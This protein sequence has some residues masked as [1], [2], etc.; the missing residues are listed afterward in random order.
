MKR[1]AS[2][3]FTGG[4]IFSTS[5]NKL[6]EKWTVEQ[7]ELVSFYPKRVYI[8]LQQHI[9]APSEAVVKKGDTVKQG[10]LI[11]KAGGFVGAN[12]HASVS[13]K[14]LDVI[15]WPDSSGKKVPT[16]VIQRDTE[17][18]QELIADSQTDFKTLSK[19]ELIE[20]VS[21]AGVVG[22]GGATFPTHVKLTVDDDVEVKTIVLNGAECE[23]FL[24]A[25][26]LLMQ[27]E[28]KKVI[29]GAQIA[30]KI[31]GAKNILIAIE[32]DK[33]KAIAA[34]QA[35]AAN[36]PDVK[37]VP[38]H[39]N[40]PQGGEKQLLESL[41]DI[42]VDLDGLPVDSGAYLMNVSTSAAVAEA[43]ES[44][45]PLI[46]RYCT[47]TGD[48]KKKQTVLFPIG[49]L[50]GDMIDFC[51]GFE[52]TPE[53]VVMGG[54]MMGKALETL[55]VPLTKSTNGL[56][57]MA[58]TN[59]ETFKESPCIRC[60]MCVEVCPMRL[61]PQNIDLFYRQGN[62]KRVQDLQADACIN[63]GCC[64]YVCP[65]RRNLAKNITAAADKV[66]QLMEEA[67]SDEE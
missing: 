14:V 31:L 50:S 53:K 61:E 29:L 21:T 11:A 65:A 49:T 39:T 22:M 23:P 24:A 36:I 6:K 38:V 2:G 41:L 17:A 56:V 34:M 66:S 16:V 19:E 18:P 55:D 7:E 58:K 3:N 28:S 33:L 4:I 20:R 52:G 46:S 8:P 64:T 1:T 51:G 67:Q 43:V 13:G 37:V 59:N 32:T 45:Q 27:K 15:D 48:V 25:D 30:Q 12:T 60:N 57:I 10:D 35:A 9:G 63:C 42:E 5:T 40:Y 26:S 44:Q 62:F 47:V 54:P